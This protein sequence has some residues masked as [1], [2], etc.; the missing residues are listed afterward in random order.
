[1]RGSSLCAGTSP[2]AL[3]PSLWRRGLGVVEGERAGERR[4]EGAGEGRGVVSRDEDGRG[5]VSREVDAGAVAAGAAAAAAFSLRKFLVSASNSPK[6]SSS[7]LVLAR[8]AG[9]LLAG[10]CGR[11]PASGARRE[12]VLGG[13]RRDAVVAARVA[14]PRR[15]GKVGVATRRG[16][17]GNG[18]G[19]AAAEGASAAKARSSGYGGEELMLWVDGRRPSL[20]VVV[21][22][23]KKSNSECEKR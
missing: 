14:A 21:E 20:V 7:S 8:K 3:R 2:W 19:C 1:M 10:G 23:K 11:G 12:A 9:W 17:D 15:E 18:N 13:P 6:A 22:E 16:G 4:G 5:V